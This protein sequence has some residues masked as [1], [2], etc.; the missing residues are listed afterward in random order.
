MNII[1]VNSFATVGAEFIFEQDVYFKACHAAT[2]VEL[3][4]GNIVAS[5]FGG[6]QEG[7]PDTAIWLAIRD[8]K[9]DKWSR[10]KIVADV[11]G[12]PHWNPVLFHENGTLYLFYRTGHKII[13]WK[14]WVIKSTDGGES[15]TEPELLPA[16]ILGPIKNKPIRMENGDWLC[17]SSVETEDEWFCV[18]EIFSPE[19]NIWLSSEPI[20]LHDLPRGIIQP[21]VWESSPG[22]VH[23]L[24]RSTNGW[25]Y[26]ADS[27]DSGKTWTHPYRTTLPNPDSGIDCCIMDDGRIALVCNPCPKKGPGSR[28]R[29]II[30][31]SHDNGHTWSEGKILESD[32]GEGEY[33]YPSIISTKNGVVIAYTWKRKRIC[34]RMISQDELH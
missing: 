14:S 27:G 24:L 19:S 5:W 13:D 20:K 33:S 21:T 31:I 32:E 11:E 4:N 9:T 29:L 28:S 17:P 2:I 26:R 34:F 30:I 1:D 22:K 16:G 23:S 3:Y 12:L 6:T 10:S 25:I 7:H 18:M 8:A 15:Y